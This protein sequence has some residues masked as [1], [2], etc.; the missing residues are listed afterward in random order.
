MSDMSLE[1][2]QA[3]GAHN[4]PKFQRTETSAEGNLPILNRKIRFP[5]ITIINE[6]VIR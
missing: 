5:Y 3:K 1:V 6:N 4:K 2:F